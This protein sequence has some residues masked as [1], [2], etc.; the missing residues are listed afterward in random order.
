[1]WLLFLIAVDN[2]LPSNLSAIFSTARTNRI[3]S[4]RLNTTTIKVIAMGIKVINSSVVP[5]I[6][7]LLVIKVLFKN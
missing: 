6:I 5:N 2:Y 4:E 7:S 1:M 3:K